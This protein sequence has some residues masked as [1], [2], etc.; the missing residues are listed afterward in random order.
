MLA[1][2]CV[3]VPDV[4]GSNPDDLRALPTASWHKCKRAADKGAELPWPPG[5]PTSAMTS[6]GQSPTSRSCSVSD[7]KSCG[8]A[9]CSR[10]R[11]VLCC[12]GSCWRRL[13]TSVTAPRWSRQGQDLSTPLLALE[14]WA[15]GH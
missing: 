9:T 3:Q 11:S 14:T 4:R 2:G 5:R 7:R 6:S 13:S 10:P 12:V 1:F 8:S 15:R